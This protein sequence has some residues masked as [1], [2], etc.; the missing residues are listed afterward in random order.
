MKVDT[1]R[2]QFGVIDT[3]QLPSAVKSIIGTETVRQCLDHCWVQHS[4][5][6]SA[7]LDAIV[8]TGSMARD[9]ATCVL[10]D[11]WYKV[12]GD[13]E[14]LLVFKGNVALPSLEEINCQQ[15]RIEDALRQH[16]IEC[17]VSLAAVRANY[18]EE[19]PKHIFSYE[20]RN[21]GRVIWGNAMVLDLI[22]QFAPSDVSQE[23]AWRLLCNRIVEQLEV[24]SE[25]PVSSEFFSA[26]A[27]Y[28][29][30][31]LYLDIATSFLVFAGAYDPTY[32]GRSKRLNALARE[33]SGTDQPFDLTAFA[34]V[35]ET[36]TAWKL[37]PQ[38][39]RLPANREFWETAVYHAQLLWLWELRRLT[40]TVLQASRRDLLEKWRQMQRLPVRLRGWA[41]IARRQGWSQAIR[42]SPRW[43]PRAFRASPRYL[44]YVV[45]SELF[46]R[47][48]CVLSPEKSRRR[49]DVDWAKVRHA[50]PVLPGASVASPDWRQLASDVVW[51]YQQFLVGTRA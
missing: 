8:F 35:V 36:C 41:Y 24:A 6:S 42:L 44:V 18:F 45:A 23:D 34:R 37:D 26:A 10:K 39:V 40:G 12:L 27:Y 1:A 13:A 21:C 29:T 47:L 28:R 50:L 4:T 46:F 48:P 7:Q 14:F 22:P 17:R 19:L 3:W 25:L 33:S 31:K 5:R 20:L 32:A 49:V 38:C 11:E 16:N 51:N 43:V 9:E 15:R 2:Q 30:I